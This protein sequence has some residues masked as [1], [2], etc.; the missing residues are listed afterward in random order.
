M[1]NSLWES[2]AKTHLGWTWWPACP[3]CLPLSLC[4]SSETPPPGFP[5]TPPP[6][7]PSSGPSAETLRPNGTLSTISVLSLLYQGQYYLFIYFISPTLWLF[8][9]RTE[10]KR[11]QTAAEIS[12][13]CS[14]HKDCP[15]L[16]LISTFKCYPTQTESISITSVFYC[17]KKTRLLPQTAP[18]AVYR[19][20]FP[21]VWQCECTLHISS[22]L[23]WMILYCNVMN[24]PWAY[25][26]E[27]A[28][29]Y[30]LAQCIK[31]KRFCVSCALS[32]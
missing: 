21:F 28:W 31:R 7:L 20:G 14:P 17:E 1:R 4:G 27:L 30:D 26:C 22:V 13:V 2:V 19:C 16:Q 15:S 11:S 12:S 24:C 10:V 25:T 32:I 29:R 23:S 9:V 8:S 5:T 3:G 6:G 18:F